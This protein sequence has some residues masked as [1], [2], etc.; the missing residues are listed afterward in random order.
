MVTDFQHGAGDSA[1]AQ[2]VNMTL[3]DCLAFGRNA[4]VPA[5]SVI[6]ELLFKDMSELLSGVYAEV[7]MNVCQAAFSNCCTFG[8]G[9]GARLLN[10]AQSASDMRSKI[11]ALTDGRARIRAH[12]SATAG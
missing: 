8:Q 3:H 11:A 1:A 9:S 10:G 6:G 5:G 7:T 4:L 2:L 12:H